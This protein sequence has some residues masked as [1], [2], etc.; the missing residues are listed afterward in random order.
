MWVKESFPTCTAQNKDG[1]K[2][3]RKREKKKKELLTKRAHIFEGIVAM[4]LY[5]FEYY[6]L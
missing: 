2:E 3:R 1:K 6:E 5:Y 4:K